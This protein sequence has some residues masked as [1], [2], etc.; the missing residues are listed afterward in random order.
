MFSVEFEVVTE[1]VRRGKGM[2]RSGPRS[3]YLSPG[4][5]VLSAWLKPKRR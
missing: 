1:A 3:Q 4:A 5:R 2:S